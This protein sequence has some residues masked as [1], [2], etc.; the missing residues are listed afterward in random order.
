M[1]NGF[2][3]EKH[4][5]YFEAGLSPVAKYATIQFMLAFALKY[6]LDLLQL[7]FKAAFIKKEVEEEKYVEQTAGYVSTKFP[8]YVYRLLRAIYGFENTSRALRR[9]IDAYLRSIGWNCSE[10][11]S[12]LYQIHSRG[13]ILFI[14]AYVNDLLMIGRGIE[15][16]TTVAQKIGIRFEIRIGLNISDFLGISVII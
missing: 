10:A 2:H 5:L 11:D 16:L 9:K 3:T 1:A 15:V 7:D 6:D 4:G 8:A 14:L 13:T 12:P